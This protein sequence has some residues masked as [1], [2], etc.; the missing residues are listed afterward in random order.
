MDSLIEK[1][2]EVL[3][4]IQQNLFN[5]AK[6]KKEACIKVVKTWEEFIEALSQKKLILAPWCDEE[7]CNLS[8]SIIE[9]HVH[10]FFMDFMPALCYLG[11]V[12]FVGSGE[13]C[14]GT[15]KRGNGSS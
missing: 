15:D 10:S 7:V 13:G 8:S 1:V 9:L 14:K 3:D 4:E 6:Q 11:L 5:V 12:P 2:R